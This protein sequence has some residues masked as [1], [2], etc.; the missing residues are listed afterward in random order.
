M[1]LLFVED[2]RRFARALLLGLRE[3]GHT[4]D[5]T[6]SGKVAV[7]QALEIAYDVIILDWNLPDLD[8][9]S[10]L[11]TWRDRGLRTPVLMLTARGTTGERVGGLRS[12]ADDYLVKP[13]AFEELV[14][15]LEALARRGAGA[16]PALRAGSVEL[17]ARRRVMT[18]EGAELP[19]TAR[20]FSLFSELVTHPGEVLTRAELL[21]KVWG[22]TFD[23]EPNVVDV[24]VGYLRKKLKELEVDDV[25]IE[26]VRGV[27][28]RLVASSRSA[29]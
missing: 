10:V 28:F 18:S 5:H 14:A 21:A 24:Y 22:S 23:G 9:L 20:E 12:G 7:E 15:R 3:E 11:R 4:V 6:E 26:T 27:G 29:R 13:F 19:L 16:E 25:S 2:E 17:D 8:G 1:K